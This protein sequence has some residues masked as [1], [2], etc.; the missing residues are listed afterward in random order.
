[1]APLTCAQLVAVLSRLP[2]DRP[3][4]VRSMHGH[5][6]A[7]VLGA[8][9]SEDSGELKLQHAVV[10]D[11]AATASATFADWPL[12]AVLSSAQMADLSEAE[13]AELSRVSAGLGAHR[14][15]EECDRLLRCRRLGLPYRSL[16]DGTTPRLSRRKRAA[17]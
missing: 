14:C 6:P 13:R 1:M 4:F 5:L 2:A 8:C 17:S 15:A 7:P 3:V 9:A 16:L 12:L 11:P 10:L